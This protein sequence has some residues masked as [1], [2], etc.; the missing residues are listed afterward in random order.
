MRTSFESPS[1]ELG[2]QLGEDGLVL[3]LDNSVDV[4]PPFGFLAMLLTFSGRY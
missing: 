2:L 3:L 1:V 4:V